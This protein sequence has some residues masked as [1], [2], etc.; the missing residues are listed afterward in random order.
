V[1]LERPKLRRKVPTG[2]VGEV[3]SS[4]SSVV[5]TGVVRLCV[6]LEGGGGWHFA[7]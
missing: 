5:D 4:S 1:N 7:Y 3:V 2:L 6:L